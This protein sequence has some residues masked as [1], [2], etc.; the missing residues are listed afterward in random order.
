MGRLNEIKMVRNKNPW[1]MWFPIAVAILMVLRAALYIYFVMSGGNYIHPDSA[2]YLEL[3]EHLIETG[4]FF[5]PEL[6]PEVIQPFGIPARDTMRILFSDVPEGPEVFRTPGYP[7]FLVWLHWLKIDNPYGIVFVQEVIYAL[8]VLIFYRLGQQ[9]FNKNIVQAGVV[10]MLINSGGLVWPKYLISETL[11]LPFLIS[12]ILFIGLY[13]KHNQLRFLIFAGILMGIAAWIRPAIQYLPIV[14]VIIICLF[15]FKDIKKWM[16]AVV[17]LI[18]FIMTLSPWLIRN[19]YH[20][21]QFFVSGQGSNLLANYHVPAVWHWPR[22][23][24]FD[25]PG[26]QLAQ[27]KI[28]QI[29]DKKESELGRP[30]DAVE[31]FKLQQSWAIKELSHYPATYFKAWCVGAFR[32]MYESFVNDFYELMRFPDHRLHFLDVLTGNLKAYHS[33]RSTGVISGVIYYFLHQDRFYLFHTVLSMLIA[34]FAVAGTISIVMRRNC[35]LWLMM[36]VN[37][38]FIFLPGP[39]G[40]GRYRFPVDIF[41]FVQ[42]YYGYMWIVSLL[43][44]RRQKFERQFLVD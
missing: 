33:T 4:N 17:L 38:Y 13:L 16:H 8:S 10:F 21:G 3:A 15:H 12:G 11:F 43:K 19:Y 32:V 34:F 42:A 36:L 41:W 2:L 25:R 29:I 1:G 26:Q 27:Q 7:F 31:F 37:F 9:L 6:Q 18:F 20:Y 30:I 14:A 22:V 24:Q 35:F 28:K 40:Y 39:I 23:D 5:L 44:L